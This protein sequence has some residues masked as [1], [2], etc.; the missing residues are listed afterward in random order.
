MLP[1]LW[2]E[3]AL[4]LKEVMSLLERLEADRREA[5][6]AALEETEKAK[7]LFAKLKRLQLWKLNEF[8][9]EVMK[10]REA[11]T[12]DIAELTLQLKLTRDRLPSV[13]DRLNRTEVLN[14]RLWE[15]IKFRKKHGPLA[16]QR[17]ALE[18]QIM[19]RIQAEQEQADA[20]VAEI[21]QNLRR[22]QQELNDEKSK[23]ETE[24][25]QMKT[26]RETIRSYKNDKLSEL[27]QLEAQCGTFQIE[28][29][30]LVEKLAVKDGQ[31]NVLLNKMRQR[32]EKEKE[33]SN[34]VNILKAKMSDSQDTLTSMKNEVTHFQDQIETS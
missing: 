19:E 16:L 10:E 21:S 13:R 8:P 12:E 25:E 22:L 15:E 2:I 4:V 33:V 3:S 18:T 5:E 11:C 24:K 17:L 31:I 27:Q 20:M 26:E 1:S 32:E 9:Q 6:K 34:E 29:N 28:I 7:N 23:A 30:E 14:Q